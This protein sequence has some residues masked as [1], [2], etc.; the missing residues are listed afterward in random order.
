[1]THSMIRR[2]LAGMMVLGSLFV[3]GR[4]ARSYGARQRWKGVA[5]MGAGTLLMGL[6]GLATESRD[7]LGGMLTVVAAVLV[8]AGSATER[9]ERRMEVGMSG[10]DAEEWP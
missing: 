6:V 1:V 7:A 4:A 5:L 2:L 9:R 10:V 8:I 3:L